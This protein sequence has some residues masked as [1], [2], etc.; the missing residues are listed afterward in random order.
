MVM[1]ASCPPP[2]IPIVVS[3]G[4]FKS[5]AILACRQRVT[6]CLD[7]A[8]LC[9]H[10]ANPGI[11]CLRINIG[12]LLLVPVLLTP[13]V[14]QQNLF[15]VPSG[16]IT[17]KDHFFF[18]EQINASSTTAQSN[19]TFDYGLG[20]GWEI[21]ANIFFL[22]FV[23][24]PALATALNSR[25][26]A[27]PA[28]PLVLANAQKGFSPLQWLHFSAGAQA[29]PNLGDPSV[30]RLAYLAYGTAILIEPH[31]D[32]SFHVGVYHG[33]SAYNGAGNGFLMGGLEIPLLRNRIHLLADFIQGSHANAVFVPGGVLYF[34]EK[35][36]LS[37]GWQKP[38]PGSQTEQALVFELSIY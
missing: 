37:L 18:Q 23:T 27:I 4:R 28:A 7:S 20:G 32:A 9:Q 19:T 24:N 36:A 12:L 1:R 38:F 25:D 21:G 34:T 30:I 17:E 26:E 33:N 35:I 2:R 13:L 15:N 31:T 16:D 14:A 6:R 29:G 5:D 3:N 11:R 22:D 8:N 10:V